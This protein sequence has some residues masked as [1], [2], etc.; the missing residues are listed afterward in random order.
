VGNKLKARS[1]RTRITVQTTNGDFAR[2]EAL[3]EPEEV[4]DWYVYQGSL[5]VVTRDGDRYAYGPAWH[6]KIEEVSS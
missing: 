5:T 3:F 6:W 2:L 4:H 1:P